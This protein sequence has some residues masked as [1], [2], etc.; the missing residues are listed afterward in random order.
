MSMPHKTILTVTTAALAFTASAAFAQ[1]AP[2]LPDILASDDVVLPDFSYAGY[3]YGLVPLPTATG[4]IVDPAEFGAIPDDGIDDSKAILDAMKAASETDGPVIVR[5]APGKFI[6]SEIIKIERGDFVIQGAGKGKGGTELHFPRPLEM[7]GD[8]GKLDELRVYLEKYDKR[9]REPRRNVD[10][11]FSE[12]SWSGG[13][14]WIGKPDARPAPYLE[15]FDK[16]ARKVADIAEGRQGSREI[17]L[18]KA[19]DLS[20]GDRIDVLWYNRDGE[21]AAVIDAI[22]GDTDEKIG[23]HHWTFKDRPLVTV[24]T[25]VEAIDGTKVRLASPLMHDVGADLPA[26]IVRADPLENIGIESL[27]LTFP[28]SVAYGHHMERGF[29]GVYMTGAADSWVRDVTITNADAG[30][31]T[32][33]SSNLTM[34]DILVD[35]TRKGH[36]AIHVGNV[37][38]VLVDGLL[39]ATPVVHSLTFNTGST[40]SVYKNAEVLYETVLDQHAGANHQNLFDAPVLH[41]TAKTDDEGSASYPLWNGS[42]APYWQP[43]HGAYNT[44]WNA[45]VIVEGG[46]PAGV[47]VALEGTAEG[48]E[49]RVVGLHGNREFSLDYRPG[50]YTELMNEAVSAAPSLYDYQLAQRRADLPVAGD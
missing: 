39:V 14:I 50:P 4:T 6:L 34:Q 22:Y 32:Y 21:D 7:V 5:F 25:T 28:N 42:G 41:I 24:K 44:T 30:I 49:A 33:D 11:L 20:V 27:A 8:G 16:K 9:Q 12:F 46:A 23:S 48:P 40:K 47:P 3:G 17:T 36:Y 2:A 35:G 45:K 43:G 37:H 1:S 26:E 10:V 13:F 38:N 15:K 31:L 29:N 19:A 18:R